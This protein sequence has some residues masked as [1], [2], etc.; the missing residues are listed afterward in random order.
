MWEQQAKSY[1]TVYPPS[2]RLSGVQVSPPLWPHFV[3]VD[4]F[5]Q[6]VDIGAPAHW[7]LET[8]V[9]GILVG[10]LGVPRLHTCDVEEQGNGRSMG[11]ALAG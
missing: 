10:T 8:P 1:L 9:F 11:E 2:W 5:D 3:V 7:P 6:L 4:C